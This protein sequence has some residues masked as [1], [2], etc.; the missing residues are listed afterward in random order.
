MSVLLGLDIG[1]NSVGSAWVDTDREE[2]HLGV[3]VFPAGVDEQETRRGDPKNQ[4]RRQKR[5]QR[6][7]LARRAAR[8]RHLRTLL[9][10]VGLLPTDP[11]ALTA[12]FGADP[13][14][15]RRR[16]LSEPLSPH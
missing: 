9:L 4:A 12:V 3:S 2:V 13:W 6:R 8:K 7:S 16:G 10:K 14:Q 1:T 15:L 5:S 11:A